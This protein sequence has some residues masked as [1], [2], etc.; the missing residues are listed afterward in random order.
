MLLGVLPLPQQTKACGE[1]DHQQRHQQRHQQPLAC[2]SLLHPRQQASRVP[3]FG[4]GRATEVQRACHRGCL[5]LRRPL[6]CLGWICRAGGKA[7]MMCGTANGNTWHIWLIMITLSIGCILS[8]RLGFLSCYRS[9]TALLNAGSFA[10]GFN[11][12]GALGEDA[13][14][15]VAWLS[16]ISPRT[17]LYDRSRINKH[18]ALRA[19]MRVHARA[20]AAVDLS[21]STALEA[22]ALR[23]Q[24][25][26]S[27]GPTRL[28]QR[29]KLS[30]P[31]D[32]AA[33]P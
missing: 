29:W 17:Q 19:R 5:S 33:C 9:H 15:S 20:T 23:C 18:G 21:G 27:L 8:C 2:P 12:G 7:C 31:D 1:V 16:P 28:H 13:D 11:P 24:T 32:P 3:R 4:R 10:V 26:P 6:S 22:W 30:T 14:M 25:P